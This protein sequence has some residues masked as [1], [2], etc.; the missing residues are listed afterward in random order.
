MYATGRGA[1][2]PSSYATSKHLELVPQ[3]KRVPVD[4]AAA[5]A[6]HE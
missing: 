5:R 1:L 6:P 2:T 3:R 4:H